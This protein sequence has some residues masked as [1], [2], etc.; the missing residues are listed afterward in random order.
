MT[1]FTFLKAFLW[2]LCG[3]W[4]LKGPRVK[5]EGII[6]VMGPA[7]EGQPE[8]LVAEIRGVASERRGQGWT[9]GIDFGEKA[10]RI[11]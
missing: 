4:T 3:G 11:Y 1:R 8:A 5:G 10:M 2:S 7:R 9:E 6:R